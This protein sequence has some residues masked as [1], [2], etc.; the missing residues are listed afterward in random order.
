MALGLWLGIGAV[1][2]VGGI[3]VYYYNR[4]GVGSESILM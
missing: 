3:F 1:V 4:F 2:V